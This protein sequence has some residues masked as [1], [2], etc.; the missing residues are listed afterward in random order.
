MCIHMAKPA[1][2]NLEM[3]TVVL[4]L[5]LVRLNG[6]YAKNINR[7]H[8]INLR[9]IKW[10]YHYAKLFLAYRRIHSSHLVALTTLRVLRQLATNSRTDEWQAHRSNTKW[11]TGNGY[12]YCILLLWLV[13]CVVCAVVHCTSLVSITF[14]MQTEERKIAQIKWNCGMKLNE[15]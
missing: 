12:E 4:V 6:R 14:T 9:S 1:A 8:I 15:E 2:D 7:M 10:V 3:P 5:T 11:P 13:L